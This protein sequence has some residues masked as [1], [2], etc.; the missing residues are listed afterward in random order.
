[1]SAILQRCSSA[2]A[3]VCTFFVYFYRILLCRL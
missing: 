2:A 1:M 3:S